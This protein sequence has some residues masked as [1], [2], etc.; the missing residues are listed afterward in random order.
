M[1][2]AR[3]RGLTGTTPDTSPEAPLRKVVLYTLMA[4]DGAVDHPEHYFA[5]APAEAPVFDDA[6]D[7]HL[8]EVIGAQDTVLLG[9]G[10]YDEWS[11]YWPRSDDEPFASFI[12]GVQKYVVTSSPL[13]NGWTNAEA[14]AGPVE[15][16][17]RELTSR[18]GGDIGVH[19]SIVLAR[20]LLTAGLVDELHLVVAPALGFPG[21]RLLTDEDGAHHLELVSTD[22]TPSGSLLLTYRAR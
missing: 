6:M 20:S 4:L 9:R 15:D 19:G 5:P 12:N 10:M 22:S 3:R 21:R 14:V 11:Q 17:V 16:V 2:S 7:A 1:S 18:D 8:R 13:A